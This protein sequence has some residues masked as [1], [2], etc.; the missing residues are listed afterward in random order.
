MKERRRANHRNLSRHQNHEAFTLFLLWFDMISAQ[1]ATQTARKCVSHHTVTECNV[2]MQGTMVSNVNNPSVHTRFRARPTQSSS[3]AYRAY[4]K[5][6]DAL[7]RT[8]FWYTE[9]RRTFL[10]AHSLQRH[11]IYIH[12]KQQSDLGVIAA[13]FIKPLRRGYFSLHT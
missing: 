8:T 13:K 7:V 4:R 9:G 1:R 5:E 6:K 11:H 10:S 12:M 3:T 2:S